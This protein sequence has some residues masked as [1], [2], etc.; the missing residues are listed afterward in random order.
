MNI[1]DTLAKQ[2]EKFP[3]IG[4]RQAKRF[5]HHILLDTP[6]NAALLAKSISDIHTQVHEC[7]SCFRFFVARAPG[8]LCAICEDSTRDQSKLTV[9]E[10]DSDI[11]AIERAGVYDGL[12]FVLGGTVHLLE[13]HEN[14]RVRGGK[15]KY[16]ILKRIEEAGLSEVILAFSANPDGDN[17]ARYVESLLREHIEAKT[18][19]LTHLGRGL[20]TGSELEYAD[21]DTIKNALVN[22]H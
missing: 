19:T 9:V 20:S 16:T 1:L 10:R 2:F 21:P 18:I 13:S 5:V 4:P 12:Y 8:E 14:D 3:G 6:E 17:T 15:L 7:P 11:L 22:R